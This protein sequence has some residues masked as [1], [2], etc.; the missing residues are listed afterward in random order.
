AA[1]AN[2]LVRVVVLTGAGRA[3]SSGGDIRTMKPGEG[4]NDPDATKTR[5]NYRY[6]IQR[7]PL[8]FDALEVP[9]V[10][11]VN[12][13]AIGAGCDLVCMCDVRLAGE[14]AK[15]AESFVKLGIIPGDGGAWFLPQ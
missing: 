8:V 4:L 9:V 12:G 1:D 6:G 14:S 15:F 2:P 3:F 11:A 7:I 5:L 13:P 10:A